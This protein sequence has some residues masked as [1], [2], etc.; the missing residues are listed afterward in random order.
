LHRVGSRFISLVRLAGALLERGK[1][2]ADFAARR[3]QIRAAVTARADALGARAV[4][5]DALLDEVTA[6]VE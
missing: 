1:V 6:L 5:S 3:E 2:V 4:M